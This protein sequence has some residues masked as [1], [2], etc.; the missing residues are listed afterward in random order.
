MIRPIVRIVA[1]VAAVALAIVLL[2][3]VNGYLPLAAA[4]V[5]A[6]WAGRGLPKEE[7]G[8]PPV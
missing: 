3:A 4:A 2:Y 1:V 7:T 8:D 5:V 6:V